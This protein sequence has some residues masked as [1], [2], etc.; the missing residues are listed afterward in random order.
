LPFSNITGMIIAIPAVLVAITFHEYAHGKAAYLFGDPTPKYQGRLTLNPI[1]HLDPIGTLLLFIAGFG[2]AKP[3]QVNPFHFRGDRKKIMMLVSLAGPLM[4]TVLA[5]LA[6]VGMQ[7]VGRFY[8]L[9][10]IAVYLHLFFKLLLFYNVVLAVFNLLPIPPLDGSKI[11]AGVLP[12]RYSSFIYRIEQYG[13]LILLLLIFSDV[14]DLI[15]GSA[16]RAIIGFLMYLS[17]INFF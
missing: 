11:L 8:T 17:G 6:A 2:W 13:P 12:E 16:V 4:N 3:V 1:A 7:I 10:T 15:L 9:G 14:I 5:Y